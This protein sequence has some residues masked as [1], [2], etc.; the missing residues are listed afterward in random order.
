MKDPADR[1]LVR[2][3]NRLFPFLWRRGLAPPPETT[4][5]RLMA[6]AARK[7]RLDDFG[8]E[9]F[10]EALTVLCRAQEKEAGLTPLGRVV[11]HGSLVRA[12]S[13]RLLAL[14]WL[15]L[16]P[17]ID[18][19]EL[20]PPIVVLGGMRSGTTRLQ[21]LLATDPRLQF[22]RAFEAATPAPPLGFDRS[23]SD[24]RRRAHRNLMRL[25]D[26]TFP[27]LSALHPTAPE[28]A[29]EELPMLELSICGAQI[30]AARP[31]PA[32]RAWSEETPQTH[33]YR[34][35]E[36]LLKL[37]CWLRESD[38]A[39]PWILKTPQYSQD[40]DA[41]LRVFP[42]ARILAISRN[43]GTMTASAASLSWHIMANLSETVTKDWCGSEWLHKTA[44]RERTAAKMRAA[45]PHIPA[46]DLT[47]EAMTRDPLAEMR[48]AYDFIGLSWSDAV[49]AGMLHWLAE[50]K[51]R[52]DQGGHRYSLQEFGLS[53]ADVASAFAAA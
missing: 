34:L 3:A 41:L 19:I 53:E 6:E 31:V 2:G 18:D 13:Q 28:L 12:L 32:F 25:S 44:Y 22:T 9:S 36:R 4:P 46:L 48:R 38:P 37:Q 27:G 10:V 1:A 17:E 20:A 14:E 7:A 5:E 11:T 45:H 24:P 51:A 42:N 8:D 26:L 49:E 15:R 50:S 30:E 52:G 33:A 16:H 43:P 29:D 40:L 39:K 21:R 47:F 23:R 35:L